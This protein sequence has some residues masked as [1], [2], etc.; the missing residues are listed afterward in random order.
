M[1]QDVDWRRSGR[2][3]KSYSELSESHQRKVKQAIKIDFIKEFKPKL[4]SLGIDK[5]WNCWIE[6]RSNGSDSFHENWKRSSR[7]NGRL[8]QHIATSFDL[9]KT[10]IVYQ[11]LPTKNFRQFRIF[12]DSTKLKKRENIWTLILKYFIPPGTAEGVQISFS[13]SIRDKLSVL[14]SK[15]PELQSP[16][17]VKFSGD[18]SWVRVSE[19][20]N[21]CLAIVKT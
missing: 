6:K 12:L 10:N 4:R 20:G 11:I 3:L 7:R 17:K 13:G 2:R 9:S 14:V 15:N 5:I 1:V 21:Y 19:R 18:S 8:K 16:I